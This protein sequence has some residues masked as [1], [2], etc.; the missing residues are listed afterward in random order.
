MNLIRM[1][2][3]WCP[4]WYKTFIEATTCDQAC[5]LFCG[6]DEL[7]NSLFTLCL[8]S[9]KQCSWF[10][11]S[12]TFDCISCI[13]GIM[14]L[15][16][17]FYSFFSLKKAKIKVALRHLQWGQSLEKLT[18]FFRPFIQLLKRDIMYELWSYDFRPVL[19][20]KRSSSFQLC[21]WQYCWLF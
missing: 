8:T 18:I 10:N 12:D 15:I 2:L 1:C 4:W 20:G 16:Y 17:I 6:C 21:C 13:C 11:T 14:Y 9:V 7:S 19:S 3:S 5:F